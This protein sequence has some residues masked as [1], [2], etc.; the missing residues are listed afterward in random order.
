VGRR[1]RG[2]SEGP[3]RREGGAGGRRDR[4]EGGAARP[5]GRDHQ[6]QDTG[7]KE[8]VHERLDRID[9]RLE[10]LEKRLERHLEGGD[11]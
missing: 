11:A 4:A 9:Q 6:D 10:S 7:Y 5:A 3:G 2:D 1:G 8:R